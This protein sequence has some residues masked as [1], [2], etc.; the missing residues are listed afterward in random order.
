MP[1]TV[2]END[3]VTKV[4]VDDNHK[5]TDAEKAG[6]IRK[7]YERFAALLGINLD[8]SVKSVVKAEDPHMAP[9]HAALAAVDEH[10]KALHSATSSPEE[11]AS[12]M[13]QLMAALAQA[14]EHMK[15]MMSGGYAAAPA[16]PAA[17]AASVAQPDPVIKAALEKATGE[18]AVLKAQVE[19]AD[20]ERAV[21]ECVK[22]AE[23][24]TGLVGP[25]AE[26][27]GRD[28]YAIEKALGKDSADYKAFADRLGRMAAVARKSAAF[29]EI[30]T[31]ASSGGDTTAQGKLDSLV[32]AYQ[33]KNPNVSWG[34]ACGEVYKT[35]EGLK[36]QAETRAVKA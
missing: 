22:K 10:L 8:S 32:K 36:L 33:D 35:P 17:K 23:K 2:A 1:F 26:S 14:D 21:A 25:D 19:K 34:K 9:F 24:L 30:G 5:P 16:A 4:L 28:L 20:A 31:G 18:I 7:A 6:P 3:S 11:K 27:W 15:G 12:H 13:E 29:G